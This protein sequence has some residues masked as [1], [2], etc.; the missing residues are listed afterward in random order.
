MR[1][2][3][4]AVRGSGLGA[5]PLCVTPEGYKKYR[6]RAAF[7]DVTLEY[8][9]GDP[10]GQRTE[11]V[12]TAAAMA[13]EVAATLVGTPFT[14]HHPDDLLDAADPDSVKEHVEGTVVSATP[15][16]T[17]DPPELV[18]DVMVWTEPAQRAIE[19]GEVRELSPGYFAKD[20]PAPAG[21][22]CRGRPYQ[23]IQ[24]ARRY[25][26][27][28]GVLRARGVAPDGRRARLDSDTAYPLTATDRE[29]DDMPETNIE[30]D[31]SKQTD[32]G[33]DQGGKRKDGTAEEILAALSPEGAEILKTLPAAD[34]A[35]IM[36]ALA[37]APGPVA[38][39]TPAVVA[40]DAGAPM[41]SS[42]LTMDAVQKM[43]DAAMAKMSGGAGGKKADAA[44]RQ[45][46]AVVDQGAADV[47]AKAEKAAQQRVRLDAEFVAAAASNGAK[48]HTVPGA[49]EH[50]LATVKTSLPGLFE[51][52]KRD[53]TEGRLDALRETYEAAE[54]VRRAR[55]LD[56]QQE[57]VRG[58]ADS[59]NDGHRDLPTFRLAAGS[60]N[61]APPTR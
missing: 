61:T 20:S 1:L 6:G 37:P 55:V 35:I 25:N 22:T 53:F 28:S 47:I 42:G 26:H 5:T 41:P 60:V 17:K 12:P 4:D 16:L 40:K 2:R 24:Q 31:T 9:P 11:Y 51:R 10:G 8:G 59:E 39:T 54:Q 14:L 38:A 30:T 43:I 34:M 56:D 46:P 57:W 3:F 52:A 13:P 58:V 15:D 23:V 48:V 45:Q 29:A 27:L 18:V 44:P 36:A 21:A 32:K 50:M 7:G 49:A 19:S 33:A